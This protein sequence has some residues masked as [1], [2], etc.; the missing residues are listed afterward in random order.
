MP[1]QPQRSK[2]TGGDTGSANSVVG[3]RSKAAPE[4]LLLLTQQGSGSHS[5][6]VGGNGE[7][8]VMKP[9]EYDPHGYGDRFG[10][11]VVIQK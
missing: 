11:E 1:P 9:V 6:G 3:G 2:P 4:A 10:F 7:R 8:W 5:K